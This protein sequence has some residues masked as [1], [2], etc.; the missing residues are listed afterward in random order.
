[1]VDNQCAGIYGK[2]LNI[3]ITNDCPGNCYFCIEREGYQP[4]ATTVDH[5]IRKAN[6]LKDYPT[7]LILGGEP[8]TYPYL[9]ELLK[10][11]KKN[12]VYITTNG[13]SF[14][15]IDIA[16]ISPYITGLNISIHSFSEDEN[17]KIL[18]TKVSF[19]EL[20]KHI[21]AFQSNGVPV[22]FNTLL[23]DSG[24]HT[25]EKMHEMLAFSKSMGVKWVRFS[26]LQFENRG[27]VYAKDVFEG[28]HD[29]PY[30]EGCNQN[31]MIDDVN[32]TVRQSCGIVCRLKPFPPEAEKRENK[33]DSLVMY[34]N[35]EIYPGWIV[36][37][38]YRIHQT[39]PCERVI[40][41]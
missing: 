14:G 1:M 2:C 28:I 20:K 35:G 23:L 18:Q 29:N 38:N 25:K 9:S 26:E 15:G 34:P 17:N 11:L 8:F 33:A 39:E 36:P 27:F 3:K 12:E 30:V 32:V 19:A 6:E 24:I 40:E 22:R 4:K 7:V 31:F 5:I 13:G 41:R 10:G 37:K 21:E 16:D